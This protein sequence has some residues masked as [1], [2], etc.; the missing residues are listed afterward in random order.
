MLTDLGRHLEAADIHISEGR[1][2]EAIEALLQVEDQEAHGRAVEYAL[3]GLWR[4]TSFGQKIG[5]DN[6]DALGFLK[7]ASASDPTA[8]TPSQKDEVSVE[9]HLTSRRL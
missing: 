5:A 6:V 4:T 3:D 1:T 2:K 8:L 9:C 7:L